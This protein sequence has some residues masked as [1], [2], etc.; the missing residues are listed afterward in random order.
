[1][2]HMANEGNVQP[3]YFRMRVFGYSVGIKL[4]EVKGQPTG[5]TG[6]NWVA[7]KQYWEGVWNWTSSGDIGAPFSV[8]V[9]SILGSFFFS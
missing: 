6:G 8:R 7:L 1:M 4:V 9:T 2:F 5:G 3:T